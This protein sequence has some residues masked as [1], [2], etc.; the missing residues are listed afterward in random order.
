MTDYYADDSSF[1]GNDAHLNFSED[2]RHDVT[3][4]GI[5]P[6]LDGDEIVEAEELDLHFAV[7]YHN[8][9]M[10]HEL[11]TFEH[12][13]ISGNPLLGVSMLVAQACHQ[14]GNPPTIPLP[15]R[16]ITLFLYL[17][18]LVVSTGR[19]R[20]GG[21]SKVIIILYPYANHLEKGGGTPSLHFFRLS[22]SHFEWFQLQLPC[23]HPTDTSS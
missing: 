8:V 7:P 4:H 1:S 23:F 16:N 3:F 13:L 2:E 10:D 20:L 5:S 9:I 21:L 19:L 22:L 12:N 17:S 14:T 18:K 11:P 15:L 6:I